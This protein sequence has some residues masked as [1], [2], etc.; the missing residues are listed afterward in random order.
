MSRAT[1]Q[2][3]KL[4]KNEMRHELVQTKKE[5]SNKPID[6]A[7]NKATNSNPNTIDTDPSFVP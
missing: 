6:P 5:K 3:K 2:P 7:L 4:G 1:N